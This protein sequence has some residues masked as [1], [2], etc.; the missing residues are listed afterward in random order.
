MSILF[1]CKLFKES[2]WAPSGVFPDLNPGIQFNPIHQAEFGASIKI[3]LFE[4]KANPCRI[5]QQSP[6][7]LAPENLPNNFEHLVKVLC[8]PS[9]VDFSESETP[10]LHPPGQMGHSKQF[11][12]R[13]QINFLADRDSI[14]NKTS[15]LPSIRR[16]SVRAAI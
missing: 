12:Q 2:V 15:V 10:E 1:V 8:E 9:A 4:H 7:I 3:N 11:S 6:I 5:A 13:V 14:A 16:Q